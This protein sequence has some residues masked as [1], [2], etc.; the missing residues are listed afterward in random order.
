MSAGVALWLGAISM[1]IL[2]AALFIGRGVL[3]A[4]YVPDDAEAIRMAALILPIAAAFQ[5]FDGIQVVGS[6]VLRGMGR[7][8][9]AAIFNFIAWWVLALPV[10]FWLVQTRGGG[11]VSVWWSLAGGLG[12]V[13]VMM[14]IWVRAFGPRSVKGISTPGRAT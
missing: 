7:T 10:A 4:L 12:V 3:P 11:L 13:A 2:G 6:G 5:I 9:P 1:A 14:V 8:L